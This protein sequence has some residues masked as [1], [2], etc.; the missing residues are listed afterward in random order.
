MEIWSQIAAAVSSVVDHTTLQDL[1]D[2]ARAKQT[3]C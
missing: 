1:V 2:R 3:T